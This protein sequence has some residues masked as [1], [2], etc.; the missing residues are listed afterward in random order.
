MIEATLTECLGRLNDAAKTFSW[1]D[2]RVY[3]DWLAQTYYYVRHSTRLLAGSAARFSFD[4]AGDKLHDRFAAHIGE[5]KRHEQLAL[6]DLKVLGYS[7]DE[8]PEHDATRAFYETQY[9]KTQFRH[10]TALLGYILALEALSAHSGAW[11]FETVSKAHGES[12]AAFLK[13]HAADDPEHV[14]KAIAAAAALPPEQLA[15]VEENLRQTTWAYVLLLAEIT[16]PGVVTETAA[17]TEPPAAE[18]A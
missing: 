11:I 6:H 10:P 13:V 3:A 14:D 12:S 17:P 8:L 9:Y 16:R 5:E 1:G 4:A 7:I 15:V 18:P 2:R